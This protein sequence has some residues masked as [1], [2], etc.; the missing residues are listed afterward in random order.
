MGRCYLSNISEIIST[1][2]SAAAIFSAEESWG[3]P[4]KRKDILVVYGVSMNDTVGA[5][6]NG[7][8]CEGEAS[9]VVKELIRSSRRTRYS[10][11]PK[12]HD[13]PLT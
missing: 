5:L 13:P 3:R 9:F 7:E 4:P 6:L 1:S 8:A 2:C 11:S 12:V 10:D